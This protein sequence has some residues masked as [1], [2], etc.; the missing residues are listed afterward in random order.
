MIKH[1]RIAAFLWLILAAPSTVEAQ[2]QNGLLGELWGK[3]EEKYPGVASK[4]SK[5]NAAKLEEQVVKGE[6]LPQVKGQAQNTYSTYEGTMGAF[7]PQAGLINVSGSDNLTGASFSP[8]TYASATIEWELFSFGKMQNKSKAAK[9]NTNRIQS[10]KEAYLLSLKR[11]LSNRFL[12]LLYSESQL[13]WNNKNLERLYSVRGITASLARAGIKSAA[14]SLLA[15]S[16]YS[17]ALG[18]NEKIKGQK[19]AALIKLLELTGEEEE[20]SLQNSISKFLDPKK[21]LEESS[22]NI[23][24]NHPALNAVEETKKQL[25]YSGKSQ[26]RAALPTINLLAGYAYRGTGIGK[27]HVVSGKWKDGFSNTANNALVGIGITWNITDLYTQKKKGNSLVKEAESVDYL[28]KQY[29]LA[30]QADLSATQNKITHQYVEVQRTKD[31]QEQAA[32]AY[33]M[34]FSRYKSGLMDL[35]TLLQIQQLLEQAENKHIEAAY[36]YWN[37]L[38]VEAALIADF[39][40]L[41]NNF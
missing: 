20:V 2:E 40:Y 4:E 37:L 10:E 5:V 21:I 31:A 35:S 36:G 11:D 13:V 38:A 25:E 7:F 24:S 16:S 14:D 34:Y 18:E 1:I 26:K 3:I 30:M 12:Q 33:E 29:E 19:H 22:H 28:Y 15:S 9:S 27:D 41:F 23:H 8:N 32:S 17:Q 39:D 6:R